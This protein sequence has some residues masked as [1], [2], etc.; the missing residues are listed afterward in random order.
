LTRFCIPSIENVHEWDRKN[1]RLLG[2]GKIR[3]VGIERD[4]LHQLARSQIITPYAHLLS[5]SSLR[6]GQ[7]D[8][9]D[10]VGTELS[11]VGSSIKLDQELIDLWLI[12]DI[13]ILL[14]EGGTND[15][16]D[17]GNSLEDTLSSPLGLITITELNCLVLACKPV[18]A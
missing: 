3:D 9:E 4:L 8:T 17:V 5:S 11:L 18:S 7:R 16:V 13:D 12:L 2:S 15:L 10:G 1:I 6:N 14:D